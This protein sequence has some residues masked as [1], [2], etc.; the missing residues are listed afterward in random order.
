MPERA[1]RPFAYSVDKLEHV[2]SVRPTIASALEATRNRFNEPSAV[3]G[4]NAWFADGTG[5]RLPTIR[6]GHPDKSSWITSE[7]AE[8]LESTLY[9]PTSMRD[10]GSSPG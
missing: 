10:T 6:C 4:V 8:Q 3:I 5:K 1:R 9:P 7:D 2:F